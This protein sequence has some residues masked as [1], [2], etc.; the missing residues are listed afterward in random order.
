MGGPHDEEDE[1]E[2]DVVDMQKLL[3]LDDGLNRVNKIYKYMKPKKF[4]NFLTHYL[5]DSDTEP[6]EFN[7]SRYRWSYTV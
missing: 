2:L 4:E 5:E 3:P 7:H 1:V 6:E